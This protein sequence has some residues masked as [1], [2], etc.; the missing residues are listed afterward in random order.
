M[1]QIAHITKLMRLGNLRTPAHKLSVS[2]FNVRHRN[3]DFPVQIRWLR[4]VGRFSLSKDQAHLSVA[5]SKSAIAEGEH[6]H[7]T[8]IEPAL[9]VWTHNPKR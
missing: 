1:R 3:G 9:G 6:T 7:D 2:Q 4:T 8:A 5:V